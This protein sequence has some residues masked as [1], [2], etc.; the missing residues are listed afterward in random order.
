MFSLEASNYQ[1]I[2]VREKITDS[3]IEYLSASAVFSIEFL[4]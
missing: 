4:I 1:D 2:D 3:L